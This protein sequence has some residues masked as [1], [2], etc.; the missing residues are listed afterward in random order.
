ME[1]SNDDVLS[2]FSGAGGLS[3][4]F[5][6]AGLKPK[7]AAEINADAC[8]TYRHN[9]GSECHQVD[10]S[11]TD[12]E[13]FKR[14]YGKKRPFA[15]IGGPPCQGFS[16]AGARYADDPR[17]QLIFNYLRVVTELRPRWFLFENVE[18]LLTS[19]DG[20][21]VV[22]LVNEFVKIGYS[23]RLQKV[24]F[25]SYGVPQTRKRVVLIGNNLGV[26][27]EFPIERFSFDSGKSKKLNGMP[28]A[29]SVDD[30][31]AFSG[32]LE[33]PSPAAPPA[34]T[35]QTLP[36]KLMVAVTAAEETPLLVPV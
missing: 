9:V 35:Y 21:S 24:N 30:G 3:Y 29:P 19:A 36:L 22:S 15:V 12:T 33:R 14:F 34:C 6:L 5:S 25:A 31:N 23:V 10:L 11:L 2:L 4:G 32:V 1:R 8:G 26:N 17:N 18:G 7:T 20:S 28:F 16:T 27:F 13:Y